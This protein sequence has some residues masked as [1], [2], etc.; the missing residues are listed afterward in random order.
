MPIFIVTME[1]NNAAFE[2]DLGGEITRILREVANQTERGV[3]AE[4][5]FTEPLR[6]LNGNTVGAFA[7]IQAR[8][9]RA[10]GVYTRDR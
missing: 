5:F 8:P 1:T 2:D 6:D 7:Y 9:S 10:K 3:A 4:V